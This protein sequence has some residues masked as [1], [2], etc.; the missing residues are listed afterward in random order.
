M[1]TGYY[2]SLTINDLPPLRIEDTVSGIF[3]FYLLFLHLD[4]NFPFFYPV[5]RSFLLMVLVAE[6]DFSTHW[7][8]EKLEKGENSSLLKTIFRAQKVLKS[9][10]I[11]RHR[12]IRIF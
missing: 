7:E 6:T 8:A 3:L 10:K 11:H 1:R 12:M 2:R 9:I 4:R 5:A